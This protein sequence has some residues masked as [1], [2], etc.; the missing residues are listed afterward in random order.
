MRSPFFALYE[1]EEKACPA[2]PRGVL[3]GNAAKN[4]RFAGNGKKATSHK[5]TPLVCGSEKRETFSARP[6]KNVGFAPFAA[7]ENLF[8]PRKGRLLVFRLKPRRGKRPLSRRRPAAFFT[9]RGAGKITQSRPWARGV[10]FSLK[11][12][13]ERLLWKNF[14]FGQRKGRRNR[15][16]RRR[17]HGI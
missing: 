8:P 17:K 15:E 2:R 7:R 14:S 13:R 3:R 10:P 6:R 1:G 16:K 9:R 5:Q 11:G 4:C 12:K